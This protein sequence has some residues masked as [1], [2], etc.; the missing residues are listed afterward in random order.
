MRCLNRNKIALW[1]APYIGKNE[2]LDEDGHR[3]GQYAIEYGAPVRIKANVSAARGAAGTEQFG[4]DLSYDKV[5]VCENPRLGIDEYSV[6]WV[7]TV[8]KCDKHGKLVVD[9]SGNELTP[10]DYIV[11]RV[12]RSINSVSI[13]ISKVNV[14]G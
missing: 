11:T 5:I 13:A 1:Y 8:P 7:D 6:L 2:I 12:A 4:E 14:R 3:T 10:Y 9:E